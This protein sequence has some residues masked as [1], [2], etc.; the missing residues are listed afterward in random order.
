MPFFMNPVR[1]D[2]FSTQMSCERWHCH[3]L[4]SAVP[5]PRNW[6]Q[7]VLPYLDKTDRL[8]SICLNLFPHHCQ[9]SCEAALLFGSVGSFSSKQRWQWRRSGVAKPHGFVMYGEPGKLMWPVALAQRGNLLFPPHVLL[10]DLWPCSLFVY[11]THLLHCPRCFYF[12]VF[13][14]PFCEVCKNAVGRNKQIFM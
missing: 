7:F 10:G 2:S 8:I 14:V 6:W 11:S 13:W 9:L 1:G 3:L 12:I 4:L 5:P